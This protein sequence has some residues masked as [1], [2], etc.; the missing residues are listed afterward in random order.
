MNTPSPESLLDARDV[1]ASL[2]G[3]GEAYA[4]IVRRHQPWLARRMLRFSRDRLVVEELVQ[5]TFVEAYF[6]LKN[7]RF[8]A[9]LPHYLQC[10]ATRTGYR[11]WKSRKQT[12]ER[13]A[14]LQN[15][16]PDGGPAPLDAPDP[17]AEAARILDHVM[18]GLPPRDRLVITLLHLEEH[19]V[20][21]TAQLAGWSE[22]MVKVQAFR[23][24]RKL[25]Q[26]LEDRGIT[27]AA[28][29]GDPASKPPSGDRHER[30]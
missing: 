14:A 11:H 17:G 7:Y 29:F 4:R 15:L 13:A 27:A 28:L 26:L 20:A 19:S 3:D 21:E 16:A 8:E 25:R 1:R 9:P 23:A 18:E 5:E 2:G 6:S 12:R 10:I 30:D 22:V 24:R